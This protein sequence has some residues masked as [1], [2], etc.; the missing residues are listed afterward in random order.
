MSGNFMRYEQINDKY[1][2]IKCDIQL[3]ALQ[4]KE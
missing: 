4:K 1:I 2:V 3:H